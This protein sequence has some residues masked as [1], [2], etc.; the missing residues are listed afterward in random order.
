MKRE[1]LKA[2]PNDKGFVM[3]DKTVPVDVWILTS[4]DGVDYGEPIILREFGDKVQWMDSHSEI[5]T[6]PNLTF[7][8]IMKNEN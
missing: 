3:E 4:K 8:K 2:L 1:K 5:V 6:N 7:W